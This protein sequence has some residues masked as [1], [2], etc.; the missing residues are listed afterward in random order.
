MTAT[1]VPGITATSID[2]NIADATP[3]TTFA[4]PYA[5][6]GV[7]LA[8]QT[9]FTGVVGA[10]SIALQISMDETNWTSVNTTTETAGAYVIVNNV[11]A[12]FVRLYH[13][14]RTGGTKVTG[15]ILI[16]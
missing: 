7:K 9:V 1:I 12:K 14:S 15:T 4:I 8:Y 10:V 6:Q 3:G 11:I 5:K 16:Y 2:S 13:T